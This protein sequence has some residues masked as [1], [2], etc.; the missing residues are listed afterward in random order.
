[1]DGK[2][3]AVIGAGSWGRALSVLLKENGYE[4]AQWTRK[5]DIK[6]VIEGSRAFVF[7]VPAQSF[8]E[9]FTKAS[10]FLPEKALVI[11]AAKGIE[12]GSDMR[13]SQ[14]AEEIRPDV[15]YV[16]LSGPSHAEEVERLQYTFVTAASEDHEAA[17]LTQDIF[18]NQYFRVY[19]NSDLTG[20]ELG[21]ALKNVIAVATGILDGLGYGDNF[22]A[23]IMT[24]G[25]TEMTRIGIKL[26]ADPN[27]FS[28]LTGMGDLI[29]T[30]LSMHSRNRRCGILIGQGANPKEAEKLIGMVVEGLYTARAVK[31]LAADYGIEVP[32]TEALC[33]I[34]DGKVSPKDALASLMIRSRKCENE[35]ILKKL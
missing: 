8:R 1:L 2:K 14:I 21:G 27:T 34:M 3:V 28:G 15:R 20:V 4:A 6:A 25:L 32:I 17:L 30:C 9:V 10:D 5:D 19:T 23:A 22:R 16:A 12:I 33:D 24:R 31:E 26:G 13:L 18:M 35:D 29:V 7:S 11:N